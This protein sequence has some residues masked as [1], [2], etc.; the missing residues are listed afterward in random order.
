MRYRAK[1]KPVVSATS[2]PE[3]GYSFGEKGDIGERGK[4][5]HLTKSQRQALRRARPGIVD[6]KGDDRDE[7]SGRLTLKFEINPPIA[8][9]GADAWDAATAP[10]VI[11]W[12]HAQ[13][14]Q[15]AAKCGVRPDTLIL[16]P[17]AAAA[18]L[19]NPSVMRERQL[20]A[21][22]KDTAPEL[23]DAAT[24]FIGRYAGL[25]V[26]EYDGIYIER[27]L[28]PDGKYTDTVKDMIG[29]CWRARRPSRPRRKVRATPMSARSH[30]GSR[31]GANY[32]ASRPLRCLAAARSWI[33]LSE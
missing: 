8:L 26:Y 32:H 14:R 4:E 21:Y 6:I 27:E 22:I 33:V 1:I 20:L 7:P 16:G 5:E 10:D 25:D 17:G 18:F 11:A 24:T 29:A 19:A 23:E 31:T 12:L 3:Y 15:L 9:S 2:K 30:F 13:A 28:G